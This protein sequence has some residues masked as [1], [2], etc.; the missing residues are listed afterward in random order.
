VLDLTDRTNKNHFVKTVKKNIG[1]FNK[2]FLHDTLR[3]FDAFDVELLAPQKSQK[4]HVLTKKTNL[5][6]KSKT[7]QSPTLP[8]PR[9]LPSLNCRQG[10]AGGEEEAQAEEQKSAQGQKTKATKSG[11]HNPTTASSKEKTLSLQCLREECDF[12]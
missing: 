10:D 3:C 5:N 9:T 11:K 8:D 12:C 4:L 1:R 2:R 7:P 6:I